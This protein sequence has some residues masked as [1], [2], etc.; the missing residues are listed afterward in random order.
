MVPRSY[1]QTSNYT[2]ISPLHFPRANPGALRANLGSY[3]KSKAALAAMLEA[4]ERLPD[5]LKRRLEYWDG[6][7][8]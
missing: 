8:T 6:R 7:R 2:G 1:R 4:A 5:L 3:G